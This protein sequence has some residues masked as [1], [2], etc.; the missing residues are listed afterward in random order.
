MPLGSSKLGLYKDKLG[1][2][3]TINQRDITI[4]TLISDQHD[5]TDYSSQGF[6][7]KNKLVFDITSPILA[8]L[9]IPY[10]L[11]NTN[12]TFTEGT[13]SGNLTF[14][15]N[16]N[17]NLTYLCNNWQ[18]YSNTNTIF[19]L[20]L[21]HPTNSNTI[22]K[23]SANIT[24]YPA[25][26]ITVNG[27]NATT[28][29]QH[30]LHIFDSYEIINSNTYATAKQWNDLEI[31]D[32]GETDSLINQISVLVVGGGGAGGKS[33]NNGSTFLTGPGGG[34]GQAIFYKA[35][36]NLY[37]TGNI[38]I[39]L[40][41]GGRS[42]DYDGSNV[43]K[44]GNT[45]FG[46][47][48]LS[49][50]ITAYGGAGGGHFE[51]INNKANVNY[52]IGQGGF[53]PSQFGGHGAGDV[54]T[55]K[56]SAPFDG[57]ILYT[58]AT[59]GCGY[60]YTNCYGG[61]YQSN[62]STYSHQILDA[63]GNANVDYTTTYQNTAMGAHRGDG[64]GP[65]GGQGGPSV[66]APYIDGSNNTITSGK[67]YSERISGSGANAVL[68]VNFDENNLQVSNVD[69]NASVGFTYI[70]NLTPRYDY[71]SADPE[72]F[73]RCTGYTSGQPK[74]PNEGLARTGG[75]KAPLPKQGI[76]AYQSN[77]V[78]YIGVAAGGGSAVLDYY[79]YSN[80]TNILSYSSGN[81]GSTYASSGNANTSIYVEPGAKCDSITGNQIYH[82]LRGGGGSGGLRAGGF[83]GH[84]GE[85]FIMVYYPSE[86]MYFKTD[87]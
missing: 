84:G 16:G 57:N 62:L 80:T 67:L 15:A 72:P 53:E 64:S 12:L 31:V 22:L 43:A 26:G 39:T 10:T 8:N 27:G 50:S 70:G 87:A 37:T 28:Y 2:G 42:G 14:D 58:T 36:A 46:F 75:L 32:L 33:F 68:L 55:T 44:G 3:G 78:T 61:V 77:T 54:N 35:L 66:P 38:S 63:N 4:S 7:Y 25:D 23:S 24:L 60:S 11:S 13:V 6:G 86:Y 40:G 9:T 1:T 82:G 79:D 71:L 52:T 48:H 85:G 17:A 76:Y 56:I 73:R 47:H 51:S 41:N 65:S 19:T 81:G 45:V 30:T 49:N 5:I 34:G 59:G 18:N 29:N 69:A 21:I 83:G 20:N 74:P